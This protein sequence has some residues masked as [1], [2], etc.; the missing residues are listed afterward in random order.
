L[1]VQA[2]TNKISATVFGGNGYDK[3]TGFAQDQGVRLPSFEE[4]VW[5]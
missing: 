5:Q 1:V 3:F 2:R 4:I